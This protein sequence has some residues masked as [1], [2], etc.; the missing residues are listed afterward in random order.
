METTGDIERIEQKEFPVGKAFVNLYYAPGRSFLP[1][2]TTSMIYGAVS[3]YPGETVIEIGAGIGPGTIFMGRN[4]NLSKLYAVETVHAQVALLER[5]VVAYGL[6]NKVVVLEG[7]LFEPLAEIRADVIISDVSGMNNVGVPL[8][9]YPDDVP[10]GGIDGTEN[11]I[12]LIERAGQYLNQGN[13]N[14]RLYFPIVCCFSDRD[15]ILAIAQRSFR[16]V[17]Q[18]NEGLIPL[19]SEQVRIIDEWKT[20]N[21][22]ENRLY[23]DIFRI[24]K[25]GRWKI[26][27]YKVTEPIER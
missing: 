15:K 19:T 10:R 2:Q 12:P 8:G 5:N 17:L 24:G 22:S 20:L 13:P 23:P 4:P 9:W 3:L 6:E 27:V 16:K 26:E 25:R 18:V 7:N 14:S 1:N 11:I 21:P